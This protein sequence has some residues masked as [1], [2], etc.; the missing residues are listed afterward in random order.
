M[1]NSFLIAAILFFNL[2]L[3]YYTTAQI[4]IP[5]NAA[6]NI[7][8]WI[9]VPAEYLGSPKDIIIFAVIP[10]VLAALLV[11]SLWKEIGIIDNGALNFWLPVLLVFASFQFGF[12]KFVKTL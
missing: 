7:E 5:E 11:H 4:V 10:F 6:K 12:F 2:F 8:S 9:G 3:P 1:K